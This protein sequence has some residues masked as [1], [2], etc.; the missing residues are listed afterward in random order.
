M[1]TA[2]SPITI[3][4]HK[5][6]IKLRTCT[7]RRAAPARPRR[8]QVADTVRQ[9]CHVAKGSASGA[10][11]TQRAEHGPAGVDDLDL[12]VAR[13][14]LGVRGQAG[15]VPAVVARVLAVQVRRRLCEGACVRAHLQHF[16]GFNDPTAHAQ[17]IGGCYRW[18]FFQKLV[19]YHRSCRRLCRRVPRPLTAGYS[20]SACGPCC[21]RGPLWPPARQ[22]H[23]TALCNVPALAST[24][25][26][27]RHDSA[28]TRMRP[29][30]HRAPTPVPPSCPALAQLCA[31]TR[32]CC[33]PCFQPA[34]AQ[35]CDICAQASI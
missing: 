30:C 8:T 19:G 15:G 28:Q 23:V 9:G 7:R 21:G 29:S 32:A 13:E 16:D 4:W 5:T 22:S 33:L 1:D 35:P 11:R 2:L 34:C 25:A 14:G 24:A 18:I 6:N 27:A 12:A 10:W 3:I 20:G 26:T 17:V 31:A